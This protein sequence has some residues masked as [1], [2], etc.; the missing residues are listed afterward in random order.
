MTETCNFDVTLLFYI[1][2][3]PILKDL[4][5]SV[6]LLPLMQFA[7]KSQWPT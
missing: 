3:S 7:Y 5:E 6:D 2:I 1:P 4:L